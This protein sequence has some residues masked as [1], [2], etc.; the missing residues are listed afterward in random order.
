MQAATIEIHYDGTPM[1]VF[2]QIRVGRL[3]LYNAAARDRLGIVQ[4]T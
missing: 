3:R 2:Q 1:E 4:E